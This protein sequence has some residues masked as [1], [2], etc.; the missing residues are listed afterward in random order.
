VKGGEVF[1]SDVTS[2]VLT[3]ILD[4]AHRGL[5]TWSVVRLSAVDP[6]SLPRDRQHAHGVKGWG[7]RCLK[8]HRP[9]LTV[10]EVAGLVDEEAVVAI[11]GEALV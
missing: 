8:G 6:E 10:L 5:E 2:L 7:D 9:A 3:E 4:A 1:C 11:A